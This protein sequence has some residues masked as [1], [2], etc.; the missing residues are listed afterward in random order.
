MP[1][2]D[3]RA[4]RWIEF[5]QFLEFFDGLVHLACHEIALAQ[6]GQQIGALGGDRKAR[7]QKRY[8]IFEIILR[9][10]DPGHQKDNVRILRRNFVSAHQQIECVQWARFIRI[11]LRKQVER[12]RRVGFQL[13]CAV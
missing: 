3:V 6:R 9:H 10:A 13:E 1:R 8:R 7:F 2:Y 5:D 4:C 12:L 11:D